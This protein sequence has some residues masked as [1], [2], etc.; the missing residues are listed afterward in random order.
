M[1][2]SIPA[3]WVLLLGAFFGL[4][5]LT[6]SATVTR[7]VAPPNSGWSYGDG[8][9]SNAPLAF[10]LP[11]V[12]SWLRS[13]NLPDFTLRFHPGDYEIFDAGQPSSAEHQLRISGDTN[14]VVRLIGVVSGTNSPLPRLI[15]RA[16]PTNSFGTVSA[17]STWP[18]QMRQHILLATSYGEASNRSI[19]RDENGVYWDYLQAHRNR[20]PGT[21]R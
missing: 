7:W 8:T 11:T 12:K 5:L 9:S 3:R 17:A 2:P 21:G 1:K 6:H 10:Y 16:E 13:T 19:Y 20:E 4:P 14:R 15:L 18:P